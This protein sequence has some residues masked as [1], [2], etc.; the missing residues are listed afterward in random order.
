MSA[1]L[2]ESARLLAQARATG[3]TNELAEA[4]AQHA[5]A[6]LA[7]GQIHAA[8]LELDQAAAIHR[9]QGRD[10]D[11][12]RC[13]HLAATLCRFENQPAEAKI[14]A[15]RALEL[16]QSK[17]EIAVS[18]YSE[19]GETALLEKLY[20]EAAGHFTSAIEAG[21]SAALRTGLLRRR[22]LMFATLGQ[23]QAAR[24]QPVLL[25]LEQAQ[26]LLVQAG[27]PQGAAYCLLEAASALL[28]A[29]RVQEARE[30]AARALALAGEKP[31][32]ALLAEYYLLEAAL[33]VK[34]QDGP[35]ALSAAR[36]ARKEALAARAPAAYVSAAVSIAQLSEKMGDR[37][38]AYAS[39]AAGWATLS[40]LLGAEMARLS[41][42]PLLKALRER[43]GPSAF[44]EVKGQYEARRKAPA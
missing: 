43:W 12:A 23:L 30:Y 28:Q 21:A 11:E 2:E 37:L 25:D 27:D 29:E 26:S 40:D 18:A 14:R 32:P 1:N 35:A 9:A 16:C 17:G 15:R 7:A 38:G 6:L 22:A 8:R 31:H 19:L 36:L 44:A 3:E 13:S 41:F 42:E 34:G 39:L 33:A 20:A 24:A 4:L 5:N 10:Y